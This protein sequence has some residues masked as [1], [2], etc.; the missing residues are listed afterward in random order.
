LSVAL[1]QSPGSILADLLRRG[2][3]SV[4]FQPIRRL[5]DDS[6]YGFEALMRGATGTLLA[7]PARIFNDV[8]IDRKLLHK[9]DVV[10]FFSALGLGRLI[11]AR[12]TLFINMHGE[13]MLRYANGVDEVRRLLDLLEIAPERIVIELSEMTDRAHV[14]A[15]GRSL[16]PLRDAGT[17]LALDDI[18]ARYAWLHHMLWLEPDYLKLDRSFVRGAARSERRRDLIGA[19]VA[20]ARSSGAEMIAEG[21]ETANEAETLREAGITYGQGYYLG[22]PLPIHGFQWTPQRRNERALRH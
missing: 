19:M 15:I 9:L 22:L 7:E 13:T 3:H 10:C 6:I 16:R 5:D 2:F 21:I 18:G 20:F 12:Q 11:G 1:P 14:R 8:N 17:R 4:V